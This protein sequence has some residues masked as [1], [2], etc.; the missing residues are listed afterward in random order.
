M[1]E[2]QRVSAAASPGRESAAGRADV[3]L[4]PDQRVRVFVSSTLQELA[5]ERVAARRAIARVHL[6]PVWYESGARP[7]PP[8]S[9]Y[10]AYLEQSQVFVGIY[11]Q[12]YGW[13]APGME[14]SGLEDEFRLAAG[15]PMLLYLKRPAP[16]QEPRLADF[17]DGIRAAGTMSYRVFATPRELERLLA[18]D[19]A[20]L[21][22]ESFADAAVAASVSPVGPGGSGGA[23]V[24]PGTVTFL[25]TDIEGSTRLWETVPEA[26]E[27]ALEQHNDLVTGVIK[28]HGG[29]VVTSRGEE[30][31]VFAVFPS[32]V[33]AVEAAGACQLQLNAAGWPEGAVLRVRMGLHTGEA[34]ARENGQIDHAPINRCARVKA[35]GHGGQV[36]VTK[37]TFNLVAGRLGGGFGLKKLGEF[38]LRDLAQPELIY[39]LTHA[40]LPADFPPIRTLA[41]RTGNLPVPVSSFIGRGRELEQAAAALDQARVVTLTGP[42][43]VGKTRLALQVAAQAAGRF[44]DGAWLVELAPVRDPAGVDGAV[45]AVFS[46]TAPAAHGARE[47]LAEFLRA[48]QLLLVLDNCEHLLEEAAALASNLAQA[49]ERLVILATSREALEIDGERLIPVPPLGV[50]G[51]DTDL[52]AIIEAEAVRLFADRAAAVKPGFAVT[53]ENAAAVAAV[54]RRLDGVALAVELAAARVPAMT[55]AELARRLER[56]F[57][58]LVSGRRGVADRHQTLR[59]TIDWS[60]QLLAGP[61][62]MLLARLAVF[63]G[64]ATLEAAEAVCGGDG[65]DP[66]AV[67]ELLASLVARSLVVAEDHGIETRYRL[68]ETIRQYGEERLDAAGKTQLWQARHASYYAGFLAQAREQAHDPNQEVFWAVRL[69]AD[70]DN[71]LAAWSWAIG[72]GNVDTAFQILAGFAPSEVWTRYPLLLDGEAALAMPGAAEHPG[73]PLALAVSAVFVSG[74]ADVTGAEELS[75]RAAVANARQA[76]PDWRVEETVCAVRRNI[77]MITGAFGDAARLSE[78]AAGLARVGG[79]LADA[80]LHLDIAVASYMLAPDVPAALPP[81]NEALALAR[82]T[83]APALIASGLLAMGMAVAG[84][85]PDQARACL[86]ESREISTALGYHSALDLVAATAIAF[87]VADRAATLELGRSAIHALQPGGDRVRMAFVLYMIAGALAATQPAAAAIILGGAETYVAESPVFAQLVGSAV[88]AALGEESARELRARG[89]DMDEDQALAY[90]L[91][92]TA[93]ALS[94]LQSETQP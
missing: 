31:S 36:L 58:V 64:G 40:D 77:A 89:A 76:T 35:A 78:Q 68:L 42:G 28:E 30:D 70:Q 79:D 82:Q 7:H 44:A 39:Q 63:A 88:T 11:W 75:R 5:A 16:D 12:R 56:S 43:G 18:D 21:L 41:E 93:R 3:I 85:D 80:S 86:H 91:T 37:A 2:P 6:V 49:C 53:A 90:T 32:A 73:Y 50:P 59:A 45:A 13:V 71:L 54:V 94:E 92:Q 47:A 10:Q 60:F 72:T 24:P 51:D 17:L 19:L 9:M 4:T 1:G 29:V 38:R 62:Q 55:P 15:K 69:S 74:R 81:A 34:R 14:I 8:R 48:K 65:I 33:A 20:V 57:A 52:A 84:T 26:M 22:S 27:V 83:G 66:D 67:F 61:E 25:L 87:L 46:V 23:D